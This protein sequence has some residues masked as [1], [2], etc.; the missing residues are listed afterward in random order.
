MKLSHIAVYLVL[1][2][3]G[4]KKFDHWSSTDIEFF[5]SDRG[6]DY[7]KEK[8]NRDGLVSLAEHEFAKL[9]KENSHDGSLVQNILS[10]LTGSFKVPTQWDYLLD[11]ADNVKET[12]KDGVKAKAQEHADA[13]SGALAESSKSIKDWIFDSW[14]TENIKRFLELNKV[15]YKKNAN[16]GDLLVL[17][18]EHFDDSAKRANLSGFYPGTWLYNSWSVEDL[19][20]WLADHDLTY[21]DAKD[22]KDSLIKKVKNLNYLASQ[23]SKDSKQ[24]LFDSLSLGDH[25]IFDKSNKV[26]RLFVDSWLYSQLREWLYNQGLVD[27]KPGVHVEDLDKEKLQKLVYDNQKYLIDDIKSWSDSAAEAA[28]PILEKGSQVASDVKKTAEDAINDTFLIGVEK[29]DKSRLRQFLEVRDVKIPAFATQKQLVKL[30]QDNSNIPLALKSSTFGGK[31]FFGS[32]F[33]ENLSTDTIRD[34]L[35]LNGQSIEGSRQDLVKKLEQFVNSGHGAT[36]D[37]SK[38]F[39]E[40]VELYRPSYEEYKKLAAQ[41]VASANK[42]AKDNYASAKDIAGEAKDQAYQKYDESVSLA[43]ETM[44]KAY[45]V[46]TEYYNTA[47]Q[48]ISEK[49]S[50]NQ[51]K[52][53]EA[54]EEAKKASYE[55]SSTF[56]HDLSNKYEDTKPSVEAAIKSAK[57]EGSSYASYLVD[58]ISNKLEEVQEHT[59]AAG[60]ALG[61]YWD[62]AYKYFQKIVKPKA[63]EVSASATDYA[64]DYRSHAQLYL[65]QALK[66]AGEL[67]QGAQDAVQHAYGE[68]KSTSDYVDLAQ[69]GL[70]SIYN[71]VTTGWSSFWD[72]ISDADLKAYLR[73]FGYSSKFLNNISHSQLNRLAQQQTDFYFGN[74]NL[75]DKSIS[76][77]VTDKLGFR[78][79]KSTLEKV[80]DAVK[81]K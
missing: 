40:Q 70:N 23:E 50:D 12:A 67:A 26:Q 33:L 76:E 73:S 79:E 39:S 38:Q 37:A 29:W 47:A 6:V 3:V 32:W 9:K 58:V 54:L 4:A 20:K 66:R 56:A 44:L 78:R 68:S 41:N 69:D 53:N 61:S 30:V 34:W 64:A 13:A 36:K 15:K 42:Q 46:G 16:K 71:S 77:I 60:Q 35:K 24:L 21:D 14:S 11:A 2:T 72:S 25:D 63:N 51:K 18:K 27:A 81:G 48:V 10:Y 5:L 17:A 57:I 43:D 45:E 55:Y 62:Q 31:E 8:D 80:K 52:L 28:S 74:S 19:K 59:E 49:F 65:A 7:T 22:T 1:A 75:W